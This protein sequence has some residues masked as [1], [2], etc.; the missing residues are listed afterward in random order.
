MWN[1]YLIT[2]LA[3]GPSGT[4]W[5]KEGPVV[6]LWVVSPWAINPNLCYMCI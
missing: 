2:K 1:Y 5:N 6:S 3:L 4:N